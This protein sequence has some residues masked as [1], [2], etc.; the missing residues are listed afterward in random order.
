MD[1]ILSRVLPP[2]SPDSLPDACRLEPAISLYCTH[3]YRTHELYSTF[4]S[5]CPES[6]IELMTAFKL[7]RLGHLRSRSRE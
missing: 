2:F 6:E 7:G 4:L 5:P 3:C 1:E